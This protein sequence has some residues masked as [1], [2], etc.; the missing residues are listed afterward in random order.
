VNNAFTERQKGLL[1]IISLTVVYGILPLIPRYLSTSFPLFQQVYLRMFI[2]FLISF[3]IFRNQI[4][5]HKLQALPPKEWGLLVTRA[6]VYYLLG[7]TL[8]TQALLLTKISNVVLIG[9]IP[10]TAILAFILLKEPVSAKKISLVILSALGVFIISVKDFSH[11]FSFGLGEMVA[12]LSTLFV[13]LGL[14]SRRWHSSALN[15][16]E[17]STLLLLFASLLIFITSIVK[18]EGLP[19]SNWGWGVFLALLLGGLLNTAVSFF[20]NYGFSRINAVLASNIL[21][22]E[23]VFAT[24]FAFLVF[25]EL[26]LPK[27]ILGGILVIASAILMNQLESARN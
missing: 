3:L 20:M 12:L 19:L 5:V 13:S 16:K 27:E 15:D 26:P 6:A 11:I 1:A 17:I 4:N 14:I 18:G 7:V 9:A 22:S 23:P 8:Y 10:S 24:L 25:R 2:G 21:A